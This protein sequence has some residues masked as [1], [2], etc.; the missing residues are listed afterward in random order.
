MANF[1]DVVFFIQDAFQT[2]DFIPLHAPKF[3]GNEKRYLLDTIDSTFVSSVGAYVDQFEDYMQKLTSSRRAVAV[4][5]GTAALQV[6][7]R[8]ADV[9]EEDEVITQALTFVATANAI[10]YNGAHPVFIDVDIDTMGLSPTAVRVFL[11]EFG[12]LREDGCY[13]KSTGRRIAA[14]IPMHTFGFPVH[15]NELIDVCEKWQIPVVEDAAESLGSYYKGK[16]TG[17]IG[18][19]GTFSFNGN[20]TVTC[21]GGGAIT[22]DDP[23]IGEKAKYLTTTAKKPHAYEFFHDE[24]GYNFRMPNLNAALACAQLEQLEE[25]L[26]SKRQLATQYCNFFSEQKLLF[27]T[28][29]PETKANYWLMCVECADK[30]ER[31]LFLKYTNEAKVMTRPI[32]QLMFRLPMYENC[33]KDAQT[34]A[35]YLEERIVNIPSSAR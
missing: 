12:E 5:N 26:A 3:R 35:K 7:L 28:E 10:A 34:N 15:L 1:K 9:K 11:D 31:D 33:Q 22:T 21:G 23:I 27:R 2:R 25:I 17:S 30:T 14:C 24:L 29:L 16:H 8:L 20:K 4:V 18:K 6:A 13:N 32:W 19:I